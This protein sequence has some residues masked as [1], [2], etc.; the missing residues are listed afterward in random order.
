M[1]PYFLGDSYIH[2]GRCTVKEI[3]PFGL[4]IIG[5]S[6]LA[7]FPGLFKGFYLPMF[8]KRSSLNPHS[9]H[10]K[11]LLKA[12]ISFQSK[13]HLHRLA[14]IQYVDWKRNGQ[15]LGWLLVTTEDRCS[16][17]EIF[18]VYIKKASHSLELIGIY[19][20][21]NWQQELLIEWKT[22]SLAP[23]ASTKTQPNKSLR[24]CLYIIYD[25]VSQ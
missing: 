11:I 19:I 2:W 3:Q 5:K 20:L 18:V 14:S 23:W 22:G 17:V 8:V 16:F 13:K 6:Q 9:Q 21:I 1:G 25:A 24:L 12:A 15:I 7:S 10:F 4:H